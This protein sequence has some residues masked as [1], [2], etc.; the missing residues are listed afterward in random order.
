MSDPAA[1]D[2]DKDTVDW[3]ALAVAR[4]GKKGPG[5]LTGEYIGA[6]MWRAIAAAENCAMVVVDAKACTDLVSLYPPG[7]VPP[8]GAK[9]MRLYRSWQSNIVPRLE[10]QRSGNM[11]TDGQGNTECPI[12]VI[13]W[14]GETGMAGHFSGT[15][16]LKEQCWH[17]P[18]RKPGTT[19]AIDVGVRE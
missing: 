2:P 7:D 10:R 4:R 13:I 18:P 6:A 19:R 14:N 9:W 15:R 8:P 1:L 17:P 16:E 3:T 11:R 12:R 5:G